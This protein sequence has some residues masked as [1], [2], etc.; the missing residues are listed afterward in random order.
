MKTLR[1][2]LQNTLSRRSKTETKK[3][4]NSPLILKPPASNEASSLATNLRLLSP[5]ETQL[6]FYRNFS[7]MRDILANSTLR[8]GSRIA[9]IATFLAATTELPQTLSISTK[10]ITSNRNVYA[11]HKTTVPMSKTHTHTHTLDS[12]TADY[13]WKLPYI[14]ARPPTC[15]S[16][17]FPNLVETGVIRA[18]ATASNRGLE[19]ARDLRAWFEC[20]PVVA[21]DVGSGTTS[22]QS[23]LW[24]K[25]WWRPEAWISSHM[26][27]V[28]EC[29]CPSEDQ[30]AAGAWQV[31]K[32]RSS[33]SPRSVISVQS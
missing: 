2:R 27:C 33:P 6:F 1:C 25:R 13:W 12:N 29:V 7:S 28:R 9:N 15:K 4:L 31:F 10:H 16:P 3:K 18:L 19:T 22:K 26:H 14:A 21:A 30:R 11:C 8:T 17:Q 24:R 32:F 20:I 5:Q 23:E